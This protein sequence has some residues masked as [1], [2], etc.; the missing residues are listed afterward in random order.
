VKTGIYFRS[1]TDS[2]EPS[3]DSEMTKKYEMKEFLRKLHMVL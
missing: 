2:M 3:I 1:S